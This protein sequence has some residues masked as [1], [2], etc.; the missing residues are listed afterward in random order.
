M[1]LANIPTETI[2]IIGT[3]SFGIAI[4]KRLMQSG[5]NIIYGSRF[6]DKNYLSELFFD[7]TYDGKYSVTTIN[8]AWHKS[9]S[10]I[11]LAISSRSNVYEEFISV[12]KNLRSIKPRIVV[13]VSN[14][15]KYDSNGTSSL[16]NAEKL[17]NLFKNNN[18]KYVNIVKGNL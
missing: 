10:I 1:K 8:Q 7:G 3:G 6:P 9:D 18:F 16:S 12:I 17:E 14:P 4:G 13:D 5:H 15:P 2:C 11:F